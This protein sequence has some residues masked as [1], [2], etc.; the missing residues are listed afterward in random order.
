MAA[1][2]R[3]P[4]GSHPPRIVV[5][6][7]GGEGWT[8]LSG[9]SR[10]QIEQAAVVIGGRRHLGLL[11]AIAGQ[12]REPWPSPLRSALPAF[13]AGLGPGPIVALASGDPFLS[14]IATTLVDLLGSDR[15][16]V[17]PAVSSVTLARA[18]MGWSAESCAVVSLV[19]RDPQLV[20]RE[21]AP[22]RRIL[23]LSADASTPATVAELLAAAGYGASELTV[24]G[25]LGT[26]TESRVEGTAAA[27]S[28]ESPR[29]NI[30]AIACSG[31]ATGG[32]VAG[33]PDDAFE[34]DGQLT[35]RDLRASAL[36]RLAPIPGAHLWDVGA[37]AGSVGIEWMRAHPTCTATAIEADPQRAERISR[38]AARFGVPG[39]QVVRGRAPEALAGLPAPD[40][41]FV[42]G[43]ATRAGVA[44]AC[45]TALRPGGR[46]VVHG[47]TLE[48]EQLLA[49]LYREY[50]GELTR[51]SV[52][53][54]APIGS[55]TGWTPAR[56]VTQWALSR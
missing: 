47:V 20:L 34:H 9:R 52:E 51:L 19:G 3:S 14:G 43:G 33:L 1:I 17:E 35:K 23:A 49:T 7:I 8:D 55:F 53:T 11:P 46:L 21:A 28:G 44:D 15:V 22:A 27:W 38:N 18:R 5:I 32:W 41:I 6:G 40:A 36:A 31:T 39:L 48:T 29:L 42:G 2:S 25:D 13:L 10:R 37:G 45:L 56:A 24:L 30:I 12:R 50:G 16:V 26:A 4:A 54:A